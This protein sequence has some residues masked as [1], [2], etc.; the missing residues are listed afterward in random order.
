MGLTSNSH[1]QGLKSLVFSQINPCGVLNFLY[2]TIFSNII[3][4]IMKT[5]QIV[6]GYIFGDAITSFVPGVVPSKADVFRLYM[7]FF[8]ERL[9]QLGFPIRFSEDIHISIINEVAQVLVN[10]WK[11]LERPV[12]AFWDVEKVIKRL[13]DQIDLL[14]KQSPSKAPDS[15]IQKQREKYEGE[16]DISYLAPREAIPPKR[17][18]SEGDVVDESRPSSSKASKLD[19]ALYIPPSSSDESDQD[20]DQ[21]SNYSDEVTV[22]EEE[23]KFQFSHEYPNAWAALKRM[24]ATDR[25]GAL[26]VCALLLDLHIKDPTKFPSTDGW[27]G[28]GNRLG[29]ALIG[30]GK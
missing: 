3:P 2:H 24:N 13:V 19:E 4:S 29:K 5:R 27:T 15:W 28:M 8:D 1:N 30:K 11:D 21:D 23:K 18:I 9:R 14:K 12:R 6:F 16:C 7:H 17:L 22:T 20:S 26:V 10:A 25:E